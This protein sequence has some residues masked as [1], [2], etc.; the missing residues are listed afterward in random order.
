V[1]RTQGG[2]TPERIRHPIEHETC[3]PTRRSTTKTKG[4]EENPSRGI[5]PESEEQQIEVVIS[6]QAIPTEKPEPKKEDDLA[7]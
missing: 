5:D 2:P 7:A 6:I 4:G 3:L 1:S